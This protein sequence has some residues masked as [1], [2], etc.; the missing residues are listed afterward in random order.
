M[1]RK[2][3]VHVTSQVDQHHAAMRILSDHGV[4]FTTSASD[5]NSRDSIF[6][7]P[8]MRTVYQQK[9]T[10]FYYIYVHPRDKVYASHLLTTKAG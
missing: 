4:R 2:R 8:R 3:E 9:K 10:T 6:A 7:Y 1:F 5:Y